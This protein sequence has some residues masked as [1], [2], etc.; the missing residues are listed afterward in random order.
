MSTAIGTYIAFQTR[1]GVDLNQNFQNFHVGE[2]RTYGGRDFLFSSFGFS[3]AAVDVEAANIQASLVFP[4]SSVGLSLFQ[5]VADQ[6]GVVEVQTVWL[7]AGTLAETATNLSELYAVT[8]FTHDNSRITLQ[9]G[10]PLD[11]VSQNIP[12]RRLNQEMVGAL[13]STGNVSFV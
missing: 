13:P 9:L 1:A 4:L 6:Y 5:N 12:R 10:S 11:S 8:A 3:G 2:T 7:D